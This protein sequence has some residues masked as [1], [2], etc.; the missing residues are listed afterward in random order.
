MS[1]SQKLLIISGLLLSI[2]GMCYGLYY[3]LFDEHQTLNDMG[4]SLATGF[5]KAA[6]QDIS[7]AQTAIDTFAS[8]QSEY[9]REVHA[10]SHWISLGMLLIVLGMA[11]N[12]LAYEEKLRFIIATGLVVGASLFPLGVLLQ[13]IDDSLLTKGLSIVGT[14]AMLASF[15]MVT[16]GFIKSCIGK[17]EA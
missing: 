11:F 14:I 2:L 6:E 10:H 4:I 12:Q 16:L 3:A 17:P 1:K 15:F 8:I 7:K 13:T 5:A 9:K